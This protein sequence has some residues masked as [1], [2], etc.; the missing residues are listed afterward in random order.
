MSESIDRINRK[1]MTTASVVDH[2]ARPWELSR[3][4]Q[5]TFDQVA[6]L[7]KD[8]PILDLGVG[9]GRTVPA[10]RRISED[11]L[12]ID[13]SQGMVDACR[14]RF[15]DVRF[16]FADA[17]ALSN[18]ADASIFLAVFSCN[19][20]GMVSHADRL[21][22]LREVQRVLRPGGYFVF[23]T[24]NRNSPEFKRGFLFPPFDWSFNPL[25]LAVRSLRFTGET[26]Q[27]MRNRRQHHPHEIHTEDYSVINDVCHH[28]S[29]MLYYLTLEKQ[30]QQLVDAGFEADAEAYDLSGARVQDG[31]TDDSI[32]L[33]AR[34]PSVPAG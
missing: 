18:V 12:G 10:L 28:Y 1:T 13:Y 9:G 21:L 30:R 5:A 14:Q 24:H 15:P 6:A 17:R 2:Y 8:Q 3:A 26:V 33:I 19:G 25:R 7:A 22:I 31:T 29:T 32:A 4:E 16:E 11:Y 34:K 23:S 20:I 27:R